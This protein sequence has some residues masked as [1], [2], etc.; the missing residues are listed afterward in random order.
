MRS[1]LRWTFARKVAETQ[2][3]ITNYTLRLG[4]F[5]RYLSTLP[6][7]IPRRPKDLAIRRFGRDRQ[8]VVVVRCLQSSIDPCSDCAQP[9]LATYCSKILAD[10]LPGHCRIITMVLFR[11]VATL[12]AVATLS[13]TNKDLTSR[14]E[15]RT[16]PML[17]SFVQEA[18]TSTGD[19]YLG[20]ASGGVPTSVAKVVTRVT[21]RP[22]SCPPSIAANAIGRS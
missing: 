10:D 12:A 13:I 16:Q 11:S 1:T 3:A 4:G 22:V 18:R 6:S 5:A 9:M 7:F 2:S 21:I 15:E 17:K 14:S 8:S 20:F 19:H